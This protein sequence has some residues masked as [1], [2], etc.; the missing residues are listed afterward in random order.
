MIC[1]STEKAYI[2]PSL[3]VVDVVCEAGFVESLGELIY[4][5]AYDGES[6]EF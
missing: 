5:D 6:Y 3:S 1:N 4:G 2:A